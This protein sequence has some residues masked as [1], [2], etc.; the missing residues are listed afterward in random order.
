[1]TSIFSLFIRLMARFDGVPPNRSVRMI[2]PWP[3]S[4]LADR[5]GDVLAARFHVVVGADADRFDRFLRPDHMFHRGD[6]LGRKA[7]VGHQH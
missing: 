5:L 3:W 7:A 2:T 4:T 6:E 1:M